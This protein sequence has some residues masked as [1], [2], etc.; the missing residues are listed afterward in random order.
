MS[1]TASR[2]S[3]STLE[4]VRNLLERP[5][6]SY[7]LVLGTTGLLLG[8]GLIMVL[9]ASSVFALRVY[10]N[11]FEIFSRQAIFAV[12]GLVGMVIAMRIPLERV[13]QLS[14]PV[15]LVVVVLIGLTFTPLGMDINGNRNW[16][17]LFAGFNLQPS[18]FAKLAIVMWIADLYTR[19]HRH[20]GT[21]RFV[22]TPVVP[23]AGAVS[24]LVVFQKDLG[25]AV[26][27]FAIIA[28]MLWVAGLP[29]KP[30]LGFGAGLVVLLLFF[31]ATAQHRVD[32]FMSFLNPMAD[33][34]QSGYQAIKAMMGFARGGFWGLGLGSSRQKWGALPE[35]HTDFI[36]AVIGEELGL[37]GSLVILA[38][39]GLL[40]Y[41]GFRIA[42]RSRDRFARYL[43]AG[44][45]IWLTTQAIINIGMV[46]G[47]LPVIGVPLPLVSYG[48]S[49]MLATLAALGLLANC[50]TTEPG[51]ARAL[52]VS[53]R[54][55]ARKKQRAGR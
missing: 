54:A 14:R 18:E 5:L 34:E 1:T 3:S 43:A 29:L 52:S 8:L 9:S 31:V 41:T 51:A 53:R 36:L 11:S 2:R 46:L 32:R 45:T 42:H 23:I 19:R 10:G 39:F 20:L 44:I 47:L 27:L 38:L 12:V 16:I 4:T 17:P 21:P 28:G 24:A 7:Q 35:A 50:A 55:K 33:P 40:A 30:M 25:T 15:L 26:I 48:G 6:A 37:A 22:I 49:S 13:R